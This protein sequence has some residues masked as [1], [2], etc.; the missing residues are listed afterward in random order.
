[1]RSLEGSNH[2]QRIA[3]ELR[4][5]FTFEEGQRCKGAGGR[6]L[7]QVCVWCPNYRAEETGNKKKRRENHE[8]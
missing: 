8:D 5:C 7:R 1:M 6:K 2:D 4:W 3:A